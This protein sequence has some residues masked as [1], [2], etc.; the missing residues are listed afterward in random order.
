MR[1]HVPVTGS[2][3]AEPRVWWTVR[4]APCLLLLPER[5]GTNNFSRGSSA[6]EPAR[7]QRP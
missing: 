1:L 7:G 6:G 4:P 5:Y 3:N 2:K